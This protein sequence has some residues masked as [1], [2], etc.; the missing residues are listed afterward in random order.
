MTLRTVISND[1]W[2]DP[3][4][5]QGKEKRCRN[6]MR[7]LCHA[8][9]ALHARNIVHRDLK[10][11]NIMI[12]IDD[13]LK[14]IDFGL[15]GPA[16]V[17]MGDVKG[18]IWYG[19]PETFDGKVTNLKAVDVWAIGCIWVEFMTG[20]PMFPGN[21]DDDMRQRFE[22]HQNKTSNLLADCY[23]LALNPLTDCYK[24][25]STEPWRQITNAMLQ[26]DPSKRL[27]IN[28]ILNKGYF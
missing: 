20:E 10:P 19:A 18:T 22:A 14:L 17:T 4:T 11:E 16:S 3:V 26:S 7:Q 27:T 15:A 6:Y 12:D 5:S 25:T 2:Q 1:W 23:K 13:N 21:N 24:Q 9:A 28:E 8:V